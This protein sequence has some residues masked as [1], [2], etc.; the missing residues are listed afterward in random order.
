M[1]R[2]SVIG[3]MLAGLTCAVVVLSAPRAACAATDEEVRMIREIE[4]LR[5][6]IATTEWTWWN[7]DQKKPLED[8]IALLTRILDRVA[9]R[10]SDLRRYPEG[11]SR[12]HKRG[13]VTNEDVQLIREAEEIREEI[14]A[15]EWTW[16]NRDL[17]TA[18]EKRLDLV[19][20]ILSR[21]GP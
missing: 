8:R 4:E 19:E 21:S 10:G 16:N 13:S 20:K 1:T 6:T 11:T 12:R 14:R 7:R 9:Q 2:T 5:E 3:L 17:K 18:L 15:T